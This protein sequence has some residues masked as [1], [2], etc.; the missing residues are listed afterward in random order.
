MGGGAA[1]KTRLPDWVANLRAHDRAA[2]WVRRT[3]IPVMPHELEGADRDRAEHE[4]SAI[5]PG[6]ARYARSSGRVIPYFRLVPTE[7]VT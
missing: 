7:R 3:R 2:V 4:A 1:G 6:V 5:W